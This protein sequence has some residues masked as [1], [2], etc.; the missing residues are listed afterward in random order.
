MFDAGI[1]LNPTRGSRRNSGEQRLDLAAGERAAVI[2]MI[3]EAGLLLT[4][5]LSII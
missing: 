3:D 5:D 4:F 1:R 2:V